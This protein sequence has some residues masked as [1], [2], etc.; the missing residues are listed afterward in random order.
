M[1]YNSS[2][3]GSYGGPSGPGGPGTPG[4]PQGINNSPQG[5][6]CTHGFYNSMYII[7]FRQNWNA[8][9]KFS[10]KCLS[11]KV[12]IEKQKIMSKIVQSLRNCMI[13]HILYK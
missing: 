8:V 1:N 9:G 3:P 6:L 12:I 7:Y 13:L 10:M 4:M 2:S 11:L 5:D